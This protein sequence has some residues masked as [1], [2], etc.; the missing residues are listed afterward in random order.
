MNRLLQGD[1]G[2]GK[3]LVALMSM[4][5][6][7]DNGYQACMM[8]PTEILANQHYETIKELLFGMDI[9]VEL[10]TGSVKGKRRES[11]L[12]GL[13]TG[14]VHI[15]IGTHAV[16]E[17]T[18]NFSSLGFVVIDEQHRFG[19]K[20]RARLWQKNI[21]PPHI[22]VMTAT[23]I[24]R[25]LNMALSQIKSLSSLHTPPVDR[26]PVRTFIKS[27]KSSLL[28]EVI[29]RELRRGGQVFY[30]HN[31]IASIEKKAKE[32]QALLPDLTIA[33]LHSQIDNAKSEEI[34]YDFAQKKYNLLLCT[35][36][37][38]S[39]IH[40]PN[41]NTI[42]VASADRFGI[43]DLHQLRGRVGRGNK[44][45]FC[46]FLVEDMEVITPES[47]KRLMALEKNSYLGSGEN[48][49][50]YD[51]EIRGGG[52]LLGIAQSGHIKNI[53]YGL[54]L[55]LL[56]E[57]INHLSGKGSVQQVQCDIKLNLNAYLNPQLIA[58]DKLRLELYRRLSLC[59]NISAVND[60]ESE[61]FDRFGALDE[62]SETF[63]ELIRIKVLA[64]QCKLK[65]ILHYGQNITFVYPNGDKE[66]VLS[67]SKDWDD[68]MESIM[69]FLRK[70]L[71]KQA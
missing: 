42:I 35:S 29:L 39:G 12:T 1:V 44:E 19:V 63:L 27:G 22:L 37:V 45:G 18:V 34:M 2:S 23:P 7:L 33:I 36:I 48:L 64:N 54:Y 59:E 55:R 15:L 28:K 38:E 51:L 17:D 50:Y 14:D 40:L 43:A 53:G 5:L 41:A 69:V 67:P 24:P 56:E 71:H 20:Q 4:L 52:N 9:R 32:L 61:I 26:I 62:A 16:I 8:A 49:A 65:Q 31:N 47:K 70:K 46:Y 13:L 68:V 57:C 58:S 60:I 30:I 66:S 10:L 6:A 3:T 21:R 25:T 11:I